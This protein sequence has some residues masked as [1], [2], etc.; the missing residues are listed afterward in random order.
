M[1]QRGT[2]TSKKQAT[3]KSKHKNTQKK[4]VIQLTHDSRKQRAQ[5]P[6]KPID[7]PDCITERG[8]VHVHGTHHHSIITVSSKK[9]A[10]L[11]PTFR[12]VNWVVKIKKWHMNNNNG[13]K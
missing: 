12:R 1:G 5:C 11:D 4:H 8:D 7:Q 6:A 3:N 13:K 2:K 9:D 10:P